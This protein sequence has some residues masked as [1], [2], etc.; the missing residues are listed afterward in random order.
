MEGEWE[1]V[2]ELLKKYLKPLLKEMSISF[3]MKTLGALAVLLLPYLLAYVIDT[4]VPTK[5]IQRIV[6]YGLIMIAV[7]IAG[8]IFDIKA[9]RLASRVAG[10]PRFTSGMICLK[11]RSDCRAARGMNLRFHRWKAV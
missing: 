2:M 1:S 5:D 6:V 3:L 11:K 10:T 8:W 4:I 9:N 7:S